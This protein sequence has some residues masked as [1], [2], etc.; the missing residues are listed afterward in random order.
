MKQ[1]SSFEV[2][3]SCPRAILKYAANKLLTKQ[4]KIFPGRFLSLEIDR[5]TAR[6]SA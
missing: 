3:I 2:G 1:M 4:I 6:V 5:Y